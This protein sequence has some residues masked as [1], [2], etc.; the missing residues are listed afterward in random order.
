MRRHGKAEYFFQQALQTLRQG[1]RVHVLCE[2][3]AEKQRLVNR[4]AREDIDFRLLTIEPLD[5][6]KKEIPHGVAPAPAPD[7]AD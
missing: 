6:I 2:S 1:Q 4:F 3:A 7:A 5:A